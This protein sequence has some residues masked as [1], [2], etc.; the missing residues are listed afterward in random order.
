MDLKSLLNQALNSDVLKQGSQSLG[1]TAQ[2]LGRSAQQFGQDK[3]QL[4]T[5][6]AGA[7]GGGLIDL[8][9]GSK[10]PRKMGKKALGVGSAAALGALAFK[11]NNDWQK[12]Q[13]GNTSPPPS[14]PQLSEDQHSILI[15]KSMIAAAK[16]DG[17]VDADEQQKIQQA[18][19]E[20]GADESVQQLVQAELNKPLDPS[21]IALY[22][23]GENGEFHTLVTSAS[24][25]KGSL[26]IKADQ[27]ESGERFHHLRYKA[28][29][30]E[31]IL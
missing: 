26:S 28:K 29:I 12:S 1:N 6:G 8:L 24:C 13:S 25:F 20:L 21:E 17:H 18:V 11:V 3:S 10:K 4:A 14:V 2:S 30:G 27:I 7:V 31:R 22:P 19:A 9:M 5:L 16:A 23:N 15:L